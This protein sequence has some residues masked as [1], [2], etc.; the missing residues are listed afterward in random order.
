MKKAKSKKQWQKPE[1]KVVQL[2]CE[3]T[4]YVEVAA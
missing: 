3:C 4:A 2:C 1:M